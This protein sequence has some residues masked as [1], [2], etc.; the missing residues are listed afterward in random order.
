MQEQIKVIFGKPC[1][2]FVGSW[3]MA[4]KYIDELEVVPRQHGRFVNIFQNMVIWINAW[5]TGIA[6]EEQIPPPY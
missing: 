3:F 2:D 5:N 6:C 1:I 4:E